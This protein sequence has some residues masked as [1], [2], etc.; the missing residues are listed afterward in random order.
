MAKKLNNRMLKT[1][2]QATESVRHAKQAVRRTFDNQHGAGAVEYG[3]VIGAV[4]IMIVAAAMAMSPQIR[5]FFTDVM[6]RV[7]NLLQ[8]QKV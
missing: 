8:K 4:V 6:Q 2:V 5:T 7:L 1:Y 3:L